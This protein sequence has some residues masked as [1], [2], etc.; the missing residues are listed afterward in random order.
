MTTSEWLE[1]VDFVSHELYL[2]IA[3]LCGLIIGYLIGFRNGG[4]F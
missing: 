1:F 4:G 3:F 2:L